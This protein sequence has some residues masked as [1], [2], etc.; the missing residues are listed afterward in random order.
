MVCVS[1]TDSTPNICFTSIMPIPRSS[2]KC[3]VISGAVPTSD[4]S[5][6]FRISTTSSVTSLCPLLI[7][8]KAASDL[9]IPLSPIMRTPSPYTSTKTPCTVI[10]GAIF[11]FSQRIISPSSSVVGLSLERSGIPASSQAEI[12]QESGSIPLA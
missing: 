2:I 3:F 6:T 12:I 4:S 9:P 8:S 11:T 7:S 10:I 1:L 5:E